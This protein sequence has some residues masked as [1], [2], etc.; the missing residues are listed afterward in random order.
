MK[1]I[2]LPD[3]DRDGLF[4]QLENI[5]FAA[6]GLADDAA[7]RPAVLIDGAAFMC[8]WKP[9]VFERL[10][11]LFG[12]SVRVMVNYS[13]APLAVDTMPEWGSPAAP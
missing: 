11:L 3:P 4:L 12:A 7:T 13:D 10:R 6:S 5:T 1:N 9:S 2:T 8:W